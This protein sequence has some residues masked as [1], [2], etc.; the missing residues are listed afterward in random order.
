MFFLLKRSILVLETQS[1]V[2]LFKIIISSLGLLTFLTAIHMF[3]SNWIELN[4]LIQFISLSAIILVGSS[5]YFGLMFVQG[6]RIN[7]F[8]E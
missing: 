2:F 7:F 1:F 4:L 8:R 6:L 5:I 3:S